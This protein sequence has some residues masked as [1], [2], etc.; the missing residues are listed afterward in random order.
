MDAFSRNWESMKREEV[1]NLPGRCLVL[2]EQVFAEQ[3]RRGGGESKVWEGLGE[4]APGPRH[5]NSTGLGFGVRH[6]NPELHRW[7]CP[8]PPPFQKV[9]MRD[10]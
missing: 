4:T 7:P 6:G 9:W 1:T 5:G 10:F 8:P 3:R 2:G